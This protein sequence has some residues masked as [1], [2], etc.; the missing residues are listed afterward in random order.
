MITEKR[1]AGIEE[2]ID[3]IEMLIESLKSEMAIL[4]KELEPNK[5]AQ[6]FEEVRLSML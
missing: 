4:K 3:T 2:A 1:I 5:L 6:K